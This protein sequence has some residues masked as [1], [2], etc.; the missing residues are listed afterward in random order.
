MAIGRCPV[1]FPCPS[2]HAG[3]GDARSRHHKIYHSAKRGLT[4]DVDHPFNGGWGW[5]VLDG[6]GRCPVARSSASP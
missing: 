4:H 3:G 5:A 2:L 6:F 1:A